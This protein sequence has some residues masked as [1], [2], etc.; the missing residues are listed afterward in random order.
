[1]AANFEVR[2]LYMFFS[3]ASRFFEK[4]PLNLTEAQ[5]AEAHQL[6]PGFQPGTWNE[7]QTARTFLLLHL[8]SAEQAP[9]LTILNKLFETA[10][11]EEQVALYAALPLLPHPT[12]LVDRTT[13]GIRTNMT[14]VFDAIALHNPYPADYLPEEAWNQMV[15][16][17]FFMQRPVG[18][19]YHADERANASLA[20]ILIDFAHERWAAH[21]TVMPELWRFVGPF[22]DDNSLMDIRKVVEEGTSPEKEAALL[23]CSQSRHPQA[24]EML[25][26]HPAIQQRIAS[27]QLTWQHM[28]QQHH[29]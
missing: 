2:G 4:Q 28:A 3:A 7:L 27:G 1:M 11:M 10:D 6:R 18:H 5:R 29:S 9:Y 26:Q 12:A 16:K 8:P 17:A 21:R 19:I 22:L 25:A 24:K 14:N 23:A 20:R 15:L 13:E